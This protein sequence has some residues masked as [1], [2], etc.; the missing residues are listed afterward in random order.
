MNLFVS[1]ALTNML[2]ADRGVFAKCFKVF[3]QVSHPK[4]FSRPAALYWRC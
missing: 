1:T 2:A 4:K 3:T